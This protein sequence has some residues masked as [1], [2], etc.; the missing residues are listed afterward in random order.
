MEGHAREG[1]DQSGPAAGPI[2]RDS[3]HT[4]STAN[5]GFAPPALGASWIDSDGARTELAIRDPAFLVGRGTQCRLRGMGDDHLAQHHAR[6]FCSEGVWYV[7]DCGSRHHTLLNGR[8]VT[9]PTALSPGDTI[10]FGN[11]FLIVQSCD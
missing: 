2:P 10:R 3:K 9:M 6:L 4:T 7:D 5:A 11:C 8:E 1:A